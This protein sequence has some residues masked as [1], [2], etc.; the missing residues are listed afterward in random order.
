MSLV[1]WMEFVSS[2]VESLAWP[3]A[4]VI[5]ALVFKS[6]I[7]GLLKRLRSGRVLGTEWEFGE[8]LQKVEEGRAA[9]E[10]QTQRPEQ[11]STASPSEAE[12]LF[13]DDRLARLAQEADHNP[14]YAI[15]TAWEILRGSAQDLIGTIV[16]YST[17]TA[18][19]ITAPGRDEVRMLE[20]GEKKNLIS[21]GLSTVYRDMRDLRNRVAHGAANPT[22]G[23]AVAYVENADRL[24]ELLVDEVGKV[25]ARFSGK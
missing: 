19:T 25:S 15:I 23:E 18:G 4:V 14:S 8:A 12:P 24:A 2:I 22:S 1:N 5:A 17:A 13:S 21:A 20:G 9:I 11:P 16:Q 6:E 7:E 3:T 10:G